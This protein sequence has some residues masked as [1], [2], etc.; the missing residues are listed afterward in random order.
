[1]NH[2][3][4]TK[5]VAKITAL[6]AENG[7]YT[8]EI[9]T[10]GARYVSLDVVYTAFTAATPAYA[11]VLKVQQSDTAGSGQVDLGG[12]FTVSTAGNAGAVSGNTG[13]TARFNIDLRG[14]KRYLTVVTSPGK[15]AGIASVARLS[16]MED[17]PVERVAAGVNTYVSG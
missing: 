15:Q 17:M 4:G 5:T 3:E 10:L 2:L 1:V 6:V 13:A 16:K 11:A 7:T 14:K 8:H 9:D 12:V